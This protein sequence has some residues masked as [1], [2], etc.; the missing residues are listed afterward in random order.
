MTLICG[1]DEAGRGPVIGPLV[2]CG[3]LID[4]K[5]EEKLKSIGAKDS[6]LLTPKTREIVYAQV[7]RMVKDYKVV[8][9]NPEEIDSAVQSPSLN[10]NWLEAIKSAEVI[11]KLKPNIT[12]LDCPSNNDKSYTAYVR[13][14]LKDKNT[15]LI[16]EHKADAIYPVVS[17][18]SV[19]AKVIRDR[20]IENLKQEHKVD[21][22]SG[23]PSDQLTRNFLEKNWDKF[24]FFRKT[25]ETYKKVAGKKSQKKLDGF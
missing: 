24:D 22:G 18:A 16:A 23:Y 1:V 6:K 4:K 14:F 3:V 9:V 10:L 15:K 21:F 13:K 5:D 12:I 2:I 7:I 25:W 11:N 8:I 17:A 19:I 20:E